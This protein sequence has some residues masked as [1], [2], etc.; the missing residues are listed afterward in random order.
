M[1]TILKREILLVVMLSIDRE[2]TLLVTLLTLIESTRVYVFITLF[3]ALVNNII[4][5]FRIDRLE[6]IK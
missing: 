4:K 1:F 6:I 3:R 5:R 2:K